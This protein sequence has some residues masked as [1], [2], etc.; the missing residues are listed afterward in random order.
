MFTT[1]KKSVINTAQHILRQKIEKKA[2]EIGFDLVKFTTPKLDPK[3]LEAYEKWLDQGLHADM[4]YMEKYEQRAN[5]DK[6]LPGVK[7]IICLAVNY[8]RP[9]ESIEKNSEGRVA[10]YAFGRDYHKVIGKM[11]NKLNEEIKLLS[12][13]SEQKYYVDT[14]PILEKAYSE[15][16]GIGA[17]GKNSLVITPGYGSWVFLAEILTTADLLKDNPPKK[18]AF[19]R[20]TDKAFSVCGNCTRCIDACPTKAIIAPGVIDSNLCISYLTIENKNEIPP[21][22]AKIIKETQTFFGCDICQEVCPHNLAREKQNSQPEFQRPIAGDKQDMQKV[23]NI[24]DRKEY[25]DTFA[26]SPLIRPKLAGL[27]R[28]A[29]AILNKDR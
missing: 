9:Q 6:L 29:K 25:I 21:K 20:Q 17:I 15:Q 10:R 4:N 7:T 12:P 8:Y 16:S 3:Y 11:L 26:G 2:Q 27:K 28:N 19:K 5:I 1:L 13:D 18:K 23:L 22:L 14:G 24:K